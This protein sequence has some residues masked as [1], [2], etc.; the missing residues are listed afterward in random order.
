MI[1]K[2]YFITDDQA[3]DINYNYI[4]KVS[5]ENSIV[6]PHFH[7]KQVHYPSEISFRV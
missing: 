3:A 1:A 6:F 2:S 5:E 7:Y 4:L